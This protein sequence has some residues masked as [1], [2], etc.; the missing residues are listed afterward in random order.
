M[1]GFWCF[2]TKFKYWCRAPVLD[3][4]NLTMSNCLF[5]LGDQSPGPRHAR[6]ELYAW[7]SS[8][9]LWPIREWSFCLCLPSTQIT[10]AFCHTRLLEHPWLSKCGLSLPQLQH[11]LEPGVMRMSQR[12]RADLLDAFDSN[13]HPCSLYIQWRRIFSDGCFLSQVHLQQTVKDLQTCLC[14]FT[15]PALLSSTNETGLCV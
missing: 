14:A 7:T 13:R 4:T 9:A 2:S 1:G 3:C 11:L 6:W 5:S 15:K 12:K 10:S 8:L